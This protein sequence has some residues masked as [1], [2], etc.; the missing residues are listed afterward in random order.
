MEVTAMD[1][2]APPTFP[3]GHPL[4]QVASH[5]RV[6]ARTLPSE[7]VH[8]SRQGQFHQREQEDTMEDQVILF[9]YLCR[10]L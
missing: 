3:K 8:K 7:G 5:T 1:E 2:L 6:S 10:N 4:S 9:Y